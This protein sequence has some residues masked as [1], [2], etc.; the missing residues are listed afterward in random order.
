[1][2]EP[3]Q[4][5]WGKKLLSG[6]K[7]LSIMLV[8]FILVSTVVDLWRGKDLPT[9]SLPTMTAVDLNGDLVDVLAMSHDDAVL[10]YFWGTWCPVCQF[11]TPAVDI[12]SEHYSVVSVAMSSGSDEKMKHF[13]S[14]KGYTLSTIND[15]QG[16]L[17]R[18]WSVQ[19]TPTVM[20]FKNGELQ[21]Y[22][23]GFTSLPGMWWRLLTA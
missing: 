11:V 8:L 3:N 21:Y 17:S 16:F 22:T 10:V 14:D 23:T 1:M 18:K 9:E 7:Q 5:T 2:K 15:R 6:L 4:K 13:L 20:V 19:V 12:L